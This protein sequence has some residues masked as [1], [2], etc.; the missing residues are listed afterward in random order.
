MGSNMP[1]GPGLR[2]QSPKAYTVGLRRTRYIGLA[3]T[4]LQHILTAVAL[5]FVRLSN[6]LAGTPLAKT[7]RSS[8]VRLMMPLATHKNSPAVSNLRKNPK[9]LLLYAPSPVNISRSGR[10]WALGTEMNDYCCL[11]ESQSILRVG[12]QAL[13]FPASTMIVQASEQRLARAV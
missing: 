5:N 11:A 12:A 6:W 13:T 7:R 3:K 4:H 9:F 10:R 1:S 8:F 2:G